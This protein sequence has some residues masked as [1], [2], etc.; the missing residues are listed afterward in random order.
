MSPSHFSRS[1]RAAFGQTPYRHLVTRRIEG[2]KALLRQGDLTFIANRS[3]AHEHVA[4][5]G[6]L[7][8]RPR[9]VNDGV[10]R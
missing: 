2:A 10:R 5:Q 1:F 7:A 6:T 3:L 4:Q 9:R 8:H